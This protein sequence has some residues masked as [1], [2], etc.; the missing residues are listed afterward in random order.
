MKQAA[1]TA[2]GRNTKFEISNRA[3]RAVSA[4]HTK[5]FTA[6][7]PRPSKAKATANAIPKMKHCTIEYDMVLLII[8]PKFNIESIFEIQTIVKPTDGETQLETLETENS[9]QRPQTHKQSIAESP[10]LC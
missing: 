3:L 1:T 4:F 8:V 2:L 7:C 5:K 9:S 6:H 10:L